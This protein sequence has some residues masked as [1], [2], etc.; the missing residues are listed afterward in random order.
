MNIEYLKEFAELAK[1][2]SFT[3]TARL[4]NMSQPTLSKHIGQFEKELKIVLFD[5][6]GN[7]LKLTKAGA[8]LLPYAY[9]IIDAQ[10]DFQEQVRELRKAPPPHLTISGLT[11]EGPSTEVLGFLISL[12]SR[13]YGTNFLEVKSRFNRDLR[14]MLEANEVDL[15]FDPVP[16]DEDIGAD[17]I[18]SVHIADLRLIAVV[19]PD[20]PLSGRDSISLE[21]LHDE[22]LLKYEGLYLKRSWGHI[23]QRCID[24]GFTPRTRSYHCASIA[25]LF[26]ICANLKSTVLIVGANF[27][28]RIP[29]GLKPF[30]RTIPFSNDDAAIPLYLLYRNDNPNP[31]LR[32]AVSLLK[33][34]DTPPLRFS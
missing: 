5:R 15:I 33:D 3:E 12:L 1:L 28:N 34:L 14:E 25:E 22:T 27:A 7:S 13:Q 8:T 16:N 2:L 4:L 11:D 31:V 26:S 32:S 23:E 30:C 17:Y 6:A 21:D 20:H 9:Q 19:S 24:H 29:Q 18:S 10:N